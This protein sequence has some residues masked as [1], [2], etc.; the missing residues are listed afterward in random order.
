MK[1]LICYPKTRSDKSSG[2]HTIL[3]SLFKDSL[4]SILFPA[5]AALHPSNKTIAFNNYNNG[6]KT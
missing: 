1:S 6:F 5:K 2:P 4:P 3:L